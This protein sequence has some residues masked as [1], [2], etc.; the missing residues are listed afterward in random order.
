MTWLDN[1]V[2]NMYGPQFLLLY[3]AVAVVTL[4]GLWVL[5][6]HADPTA[7]EP[8]PPVPSEPDPYATA[9]LR[10]GLGEVTRVAVFE[11]LQRGYLT[12]ES[13]LFETAHDAPDV[14]HLHPVARVAYR[15]F[16]TKSASSVREV[17]AKDGLAAK[18]RESVEARLRAPLA[19]ERLLATDRMK[20]VRLGLTA[21]VA[22]LV[23]AFGGYKLT[24][25]LTKGHTN[26]LF[27]IVLLLAALAG[28]VAIYVKTPPL[29]ARGRKYLAGLSLAFNQV[30]SRPDPSGASPYLP[31][32][33]GLFGVTA[34]AGTS[35][36]FLADELEQLQRSAQTTS[37]GWNGSCG[38]NC[39]GGCGSG[40]GGGCGGCGGCG[41]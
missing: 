40:C 22:G 31:L 9:Y 26:V 38:S 19:A 27:L 18:L 12:N 5:L 37:T 1:P 23:V 10:G 34:L 16:E 28:A 24:V 17:F 39:G 21:V 15:W 2:A 41:G 7:G 8:A 4:G 30:S 25:A 13:R 36:A 6:R 14:R 29:T 11:L 35:Y 3:L 33:V 20:R 32:M